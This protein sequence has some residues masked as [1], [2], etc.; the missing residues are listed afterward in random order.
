[1][2]KFLSKKARE[3][4]P[5]IAGIQ[6]K[7][8]GWIKLNTN[9]NPYPPKLKLNDNLS[10]ILDNLRLYPDSDANA[11][12]DKIADDLNAKNGTNLTREN[13]FVGNG[14]D[15]VLAIIF[16]TF[17]SGKTLCVPDVSYSFYP[18]WAQMYDVTPKVIATKNWGINWGDYSGNCII[19]NP[20]A[21]TSLAID[22]ERIP[23]G[24]VVVIDEA[25]IDFAEAE[26]AVRLIGDNDNLL[27][28]RTFSKSYS[29]A[30]LRVGYAIGDSALI[31][32]LNR[33]KNS[34]NS[35]PVD[36]LAQKIA[37]L[38]EPNV[39]EVIA[40]REWLKT[41]ID[42]LDSQANFVWWNVENAEEMYEYLLKNKILVR[43]WKQF[44]NN[45]RVTIGTQNDMEEF[46]K[47]IEKLTRPK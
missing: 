11:L 33:I 20:N 4:Q 41:K 22:I 46:V 30:G 1:M 7:G 32:G 9:E 24:G 47:C 40:T 36:A 38:A 27:V 28:V 6:P 10:E 14:S 39:D 43:Y 15:E 19:A 26:S 21:P 44:P 37:M 45:L 42:C 13:V 2:D 23:Q 3:I 25:Y 31:E 17:F 12:R 18:V 16:Q 8:D 34:F 5:Y 29:L 35:Y